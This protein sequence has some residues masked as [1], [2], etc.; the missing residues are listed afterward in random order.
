MRINLHQWPQGFYPGIYKPAFWEIALW[1]VLLKDNKAL[2]Y[3][4]FKELPHMNYRLPNSI[5]PAEFGRFSFMNFFCP[6]SMD[7]T[8]LNLRWKKLIFPSEIPTIR[9][10]SA[11]RYW[12]LIKNMLFIHLTSHGLVK[13]IEVYFKGVNLCA[14]IYLCAVICR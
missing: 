4:S 7:H 11:V 5:W 3:S 6:F 2:T 12:N 13:G 1:S 10:R 9:N 8:K 14:G